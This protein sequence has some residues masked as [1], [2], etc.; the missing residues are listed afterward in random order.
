[1]YYDVIYLYVEFYDVEDLYYIEDICCRIVDECI[2]NII[3]TMDWYV[4]KY[5]DDY[6]TCLYTEL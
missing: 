6:L 5:K 2:L 3:E 1:M 4:L